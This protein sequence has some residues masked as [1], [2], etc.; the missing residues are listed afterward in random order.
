MAVRMPPRALFWLFP[1]V[2]RASAWLARRF[3]PAGRLVLSLMVAGTLFGVDLRQTLAY[4]LAALAFALLL[5]SMAANIYWRPRLQVRRV[6][7]DYVTADTP[8]NYFI[9]IT[10]TGPHLERDLA[11]KDVLGQPHLGYRRFQQ[12]RHATPS[13]RNWFD[14]VVGFPRW[15]EIRQ[16]DRGANLDIIEIPAVAPGATIRVAVAATPLR[17]GLLQFEC[18][19]L[20]RPDP[21][22]LVRT[23]RRYSLP[24][25]LLALPRRYAMPAFHLAAERHYQRGGISLALAVGDS[26]EFASLRD[27][28]PGDPRRHIHWRSFAKTGELIV[29]EYQDEY[30][31]R[32]ALVVDTHLA[33]APEVVFETVISVAASITSSE[34]PQ[35]SILDL[36]FT[37]NE[38]IELSTGRGLGDAVR[39]LTYL[40]EATP[41]R[42]GR[43]EDLAA[44]I[45]ERSAQLASVIVVLGEWDA[46]RES[47]VDELG[48]RALPSASLLVTTDSEPALPRH[49]GG[50]A[51]FTVRTA[52]AAEDLARVRIGVDSSS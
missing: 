6:L 17:R 30:F 47:L 33:G 50:H 16:R 43:F 39:A 26:Q 18:I 45:R 32:H 12:L 8:M 35:D 4:Q 19:E 29:K 5:A 41:A 20:L 24:Q 3:T 15:V 21:L 9:E 11:L 1:L 10:N 13:R 44:R 52:H 38:V 27:Y 28:R 25:K 7:P 34:R 14:R 40:A 48:S 42:D 46:A 22:G 2:G 31:D 51:V 37:G 23:R 49:R 36:M